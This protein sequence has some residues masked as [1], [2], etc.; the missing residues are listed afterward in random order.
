MKLILR[1]S[2]S[3]LILFS[4]SCSKKNIRIQVLKP[5]PISIPQ[6]IKTIAIVNHTIPIN[7]IWDIV[8]GILTGEIIEQDKKGKQEVLIGLS[9][10]MKETSR[11]NVIL[12]TEIFKGSGSISGK[13]FPTPLSWHNI[14]MLCRKYKADAVLSLENY[15]SDYIVTSAVKKKTDSDEG[16]SQTIFVAKGIAAINIGFRLYEPKKKNIMDQESFDHSRT[17]RAEGKNP[18][19]AIAHLMLKANAVYKASYDAGKAYG[20]RI[21]PHYIWVNRMYYKKGKKS[22]DIAIGARQADTGEWE[23]AIKTWKKA[24]NSPHKKDPG[25]AAMN[26]AMGYEMTGNLDKALEWARKSYSKYENNDALK[27]VNQIEQRIEDENRLD[28]QLS[29]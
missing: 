26:I 22:N 9:N 3:V 21:T 20:H 7:K 13:T 6:N 19:D 25:R 17:W 28:E 10:A 24:L 2:L 8:E 5:A 29:N 4:L 16:G 11:Y 18:A 27:F 12:T 1:L 15:D 23:E 14:E